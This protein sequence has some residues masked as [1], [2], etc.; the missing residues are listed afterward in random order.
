[1][2]MSFL[3]PIWKNETFVKRILKN[4]IDVDPSS[5]NIALFQ[6][7]AKELNRIPTKEDW[8]LNLV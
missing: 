8:V 6:L 5:N 2:K 3:M 7:L 1:M 4:C